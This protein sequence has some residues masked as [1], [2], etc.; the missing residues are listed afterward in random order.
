M[1]NRIQ[2][3]LAAMLVLSASHISADSASCATNK[4]FLT[5]R[6]HGVNLALEKTAGWP[7][8]MDRHDQE[9]A[10]G[11]DMQASFFVMGS[12]NE[13]AI[14]RYFL[15]KPTST[16]AL[17]NNDCASVTLPRTIVWDDIHGDFYVADSDAAG[18]AANLTAGL[19]DLG[20][21]VHD[22]YS[23]SDGYTLP[24]TDTKLQLCPEH[25]AI[26]VTFNYHQDLKHLLKGLY[27]E[28]AIPV[29]RVENT[30]GV[31][32]SGTTGTDAADLLK[33]LEG[34]R[35]EFAINADNGRAFVN[36]DHA[37]FD[38]N[39]V[40]AT[41]VADVDLMLGYTLLEKAKYHAALNFG[42]TIPTG[43]EPDGEWVFDAVVG[44][45][46]HIGLGFGLEA[47]AKLW[48]SDCG[49]HSL[50]LNLAMNYRYLLN[51]DQFRTL[52]LKN[53]VGLNGTAISNNFS[54]YYLL[55]DRTEQ[56]NEQQLKPAANITTLNLNVVPGNQ[57]DAIL[58]LNYNWK[59]FAFDFGYNLFFREKENV[60]M[61][62]VC[63]KTTQFTDGQWAVATRSVDMTDTVDSL[64]PSAS[65]P[66]TVDSVG[67]FYGNHL[68]LCNVDTENLDLDSAATPRLLSHKLYVGA[69]YWTKT[70]E[71]PILVGVGGH[72]EFADCD[73]ISNWGFNAR[74]GVG[75]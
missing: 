63:G 6:S 38:L 42:I 64:T 12:T 22:P 32:T 14:A 73:I 27:V 71:V 19:L 13:D 67:V 66:M 48:E 68:M 29:V 47:D 74:L 54:Q 52:G 53:L 11:A 51:N 26:G 28:I 7:N 56:P 18:S 43:D 45:N 1:K 65:T 58:A 16:N 17:C 2:L 40:V 34:A 55:I 37:K 46:K 15:Y 20:L 75:F 8:L 39:P 49:D 9:E 60:T 57:V 50:Q 70:W 59:G 25:K 69:G 41:G 3:L 33:F 44:N 5:P 72:Y 10:F 4:K 21:L 36:L 31:S 23:G 24:S 35:A 62:T 61:G 30:I